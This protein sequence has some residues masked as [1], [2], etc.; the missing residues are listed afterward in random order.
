MEVT[1]KKYRINEHLDKLTM[2]E[3]RIIMKIIPHILEISGNTFQNY[4]NIEL[5]SKQDIPYEKVRML[6]ILFDIGAGELQNFEITGL[7][8]KTI[9]SNGTYQ[10]II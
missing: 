4:R 5:G 9:L 6:E 3:H 2:K 1:I 7:S 10:H 8:F